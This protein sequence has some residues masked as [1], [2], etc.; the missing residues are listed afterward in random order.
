MHRITIL[1]KSDINSLIQLSSSQDIFN[2]TVSFFIKFNNIQ[3]KNI[4]I[5]K[6]LKETNKKSLD[7][8]EKFFFLKGLE[9]NLEIVQQIFENLLPKKICKKRGVVYTPKIIANYLINK[10]ITK[11]TQTIC[12]C[13]CGTGIFLLQAVK[14]LYALKKTSISSIIQNN[15]F[16]SD[17]I[18]DHIEY[19]KIILTL[20]MLSFHE[21]KKTLNFNL[22]TA[23][24]LKMDWRN[25]YPKIFKHGG[26]DVVVGNPPYVRIQDMSNKEKNELES[27]WKTCKSSFNLYFP[28]FELEF[29]SMLGIFIIFLVIPLSIKKVFPS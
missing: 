25:Y 3:T 15:I 7:L 22:V 11:N 6:I 14:K 21:D 26:F 17:I 4:Q 2:C 18:E 29:L 16:G 24:S 5:H 9:I 19:T 20:Y 13:S 28:F 23:D 12:D 8:Y 10:T 27:K 1:S